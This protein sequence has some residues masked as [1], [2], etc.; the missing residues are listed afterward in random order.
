[1]SDIKITKQELKFRASTS[2]DV[3][4]YSLVV[5][6]TGLGFQRDL[7]GTLLDGNGDPVIRVDLVDN[8]P[9]ADGFITDDLSKYMPLHVLDGVF[10][11]GLIVVDDSGNESSIFVLEN[12]ALDFTVPDAVIEAFMIR[13]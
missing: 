12:E 1:M 4:H 8:T 5:G 6:P 11:L 13:S 9:D 2:P 3:D 10:D 7:A